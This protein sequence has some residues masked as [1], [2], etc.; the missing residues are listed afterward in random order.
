[1][2]VSDPISNMLTTIKNALKVRKE[3]VDVPAS[4]LKEKIL[5]IFKKDGYIEDVRLL[6]DNKQGVLKVY[7]KYENKKPAI[8]GLKR[9][10]KPGL[11]TYVPNDA[12]PKV[13]NGLGTAV[14]S[15]SKGIVD[16][17]EARQLKIGG[18]V[19]CYIW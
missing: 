6:K 4:V 7:L 13:L 5:G 17:K 1:M 9:V 18:E 14:L 8:T 15:T 10:S 2:A 19:L 16:D 3:T 11:R 12:I